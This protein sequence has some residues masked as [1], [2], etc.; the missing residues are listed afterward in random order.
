MVVK[1]ETILSSLSN[2]ATINDFEPG[3]YYWK[4]VLLDED[5][6]LILDS[7]SR[8]I[9]IKES[10]EMPDIISPK[11]GYA[12]NMSNKDE[13]SLLWKQVVG[14][15]F[16]RLNLYRVKNGRKYRVAY[17]EQKGNSYKIT[18]LR[19]L[20]TGNFHWTLQAFESKDNAIIRK[21]SVVESN[22][23]ITLGKPME[24]ADINSL[25]IENL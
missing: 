20:D 25:K 5:G 12:I 9:T 13:L 18:D 2:A 19:K 1:K 17:S 8:S 10:L 16:Y 15:D 4:V 23:N 21:S 11:N 3:V 22:F 7:K 14:A 6:T 24:K